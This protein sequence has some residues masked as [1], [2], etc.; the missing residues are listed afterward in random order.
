[1]FYGAPT[2]SAGPVRGTHAVGHRHEG[3]PLS[4]FRRTLLGFQIFTWNV[5][6]I[7]SLV[8]V[9]VFWTVLVRTAG[10]N[11]SACVVRFFA[12]RNTNAANFKLCG[13]RPHCL[14]E[15]CF[16]TCR[17]P[18][19]QYGVER[20]V[21]RIVFVRRTRSARCMHAALAA[22]RAVRR[23]WIAWRFLNLGG[24]WSDRYASGFLAADSEFRAFKQ[25]QQGALSC[26]SSSA[27]A[28]TGSQKLEAL[29]HRRLVELTDQTLAV[30][31]RWINKWGNSN[32]SCFTLATW[33]CSMQ[34]DDTRLSTTDVNAHALIAVVLVSGRA[35]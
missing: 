11:T 14:L 34:Y 35:K 7:G 22:R 3:E 33:M 27:R 28:M 32:E 15:A 4:N 18:S 26:R 17:P 20:N 6:C 23:T 24:S 25:G 1:M 29:T 2:A 30:G 13:R 21:R 9:T 12:E 5:A 19:V 31:S 10:R 16:G 8:V